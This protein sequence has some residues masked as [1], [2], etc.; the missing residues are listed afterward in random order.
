LLN[1]PADLEALAEIDRLRSTLNRN[2]NNDQQ[3]IENEFMN[4]TKSF[5]GLNID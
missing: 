4:F 5:A 2:D 3:N 1:C